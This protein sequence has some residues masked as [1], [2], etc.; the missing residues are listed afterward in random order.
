LRQDFP[1]SLAADAELGVETLVEWAETH[2][3][4][5]LRADRRRSPSLT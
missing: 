4:S 2:K 1:A 3:E 5:K